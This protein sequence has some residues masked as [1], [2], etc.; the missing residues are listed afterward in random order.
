MVAGLLHPL[1]IFIIGLGGGFLIPL[2]YRLGQAW[3]SAV[4]VAALAGMTLISGVCLVDLANG[5]APIEILTGGAAPPYAINLRVGLPESIFAFAVNVIALLGAW[6]FV[7]A[8]YATILLYLIIVMGIQGMVMTRDLF[9]LFV[10]LE[11]VSIATYG[12]LSLQ[13]TP[14]ALSATFKYLMATVLASTFFLIGVVLLYSV[15]GMLN[16][17]DVIA[18]KEVIVGPIGFA[19]LIFMLT[20]LL[21]ELKPFP[22]NGWGLDVYETAHSGV[23]ALIAVGVTAGVFFALLKLLPLF[24]EQ[25]GVIA[26]LGAVTFIASNLIGLQQDNARRLLG[27]SSIGQMGLMTMAVA[28]LQQHD[29]AGTTQLI[30]AGLFINH[31]LAKAALFWLAGYVGKSRLDDWSVLAGRPVIILAFAILLSAI[32]GF[33][34]FPGFWAKWHLV[35]VLAAQDQYTWIVVG[36][37][38]SLLEAAYLFRWFGRIVHRTGGANQDALSS[39]GADLLPIFGAAAL[40]I[41]T[42]I[43]G[44]VLAG[45]TSFWVFAPLLS[46]IVLFTLDGLAGRAKALLAAF[47]VLVV[48]FWLV[49]DQSGINYLFAALLYAGGVVLSIACLYR[50]DSRPGFHALLVVLLLSL[51]ALPRAATSLEFFFIWELITLSSYFLVVRRQE[52]AAQAL[53]Y[54]LFSLVA[55]FFLLVGF[56]M[57]HAISGTTSLS[58]LRMSGPE[59]STV[60]VLFAIGLLIKAG[61]IG[62]HVWLPGVYAESDDDVSAILSALVSKASMFGLLVCTYVAVRSDVTLELAH[63]LGWIGMLTTLAGAMMAVRQDDMKRMLAYSSMS[64]LGYIVTAI[65]LLSHLGWVTALYL[66]ANHLMVKGILFLTAAA[67]IL[68]RGSRRFVDIRGIAWSMPLTFAAAVVAIVAMS[69]LPPLAGF[70]GK[71]MLLSAMMERGWYG[72]LVVGVLA[73]FVGFLYMV[74]FILVAFLSRPASPRRGMDAPLPILAAQC[75][76]IA[77]ILVVSFYPKLLIGPVSAAIDPTFA[78]T[79]VWQ[80]MSLEMIYGSWNPVPAMALAVVASAILFAVFWL[81]QRTGWFVA[82]AQRAESADKAAAPFPVFNPLFTAMT[83]PLARTFWDG[84]SAGTLIGA[85][86]ARRVYTGNGQTYCLYILYYFV[87]LYALCGGLDRVWAVGL[88]I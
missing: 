40:L 23:A 88:K 34:P 80:G 56:A 41:V 73:T 35:L 83:P 30:V 59:S 39:S 27:Y 6:Y 4:F 78:S 52:S 51:P 50:G 64:Q 20:C 58:A 87:V 31:L 79:L 70:G 57:A 75:L 1:N 84:V 68:R 14:A 62:V 2:V 77:G 49:R 54:L 9:N 48:G 15:T 66:V 60:F 5:A 12:L 85:D 24:G 13:Q 74:R 26:A 72:P 42:G 76:L 86:R 47:V 46:G 32:A 16:I 11:I 67:V 7:R 3:L 38:G 21:V 71:W 65:A 61:A 36:L 43:V 44:A 69:G 10:F 53:P 17:D 19:A 45:M 18:K 37:L 29:A 25:L 33:P 82:F 55:A 81:I 22:A 28:L 63:V 8:K